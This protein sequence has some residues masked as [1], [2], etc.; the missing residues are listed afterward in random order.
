MLCMT[1]IQFEQ[2]VADFFQH[3]GYTVETTPRSYDYGVDIVVSNK[4]GRTA[5]QVKMYEQ[6]QVNYQDVMYLFAGKVIYGCSSG[7]LVTSGQLSANARR[8]AETLD[9]EVM[10]NWKS[11][12]LE[13][14][15]VSSEASDTSSQAEVS[16]RSF[17][18]VWEK[19]IVP[20][21][22]KK[23][24]TSTHKENLICDV[25]WDYIERESS[26][27]RASKISFTVFRSCYAYILENGRMTREEINHLY[28]KR[29]SAAIFAVL[30]C[31]PHLKVELNPATLVLESDRSQE[32]E[33]R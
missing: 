18:E 31:I 20:L 22:S 21:K 1:P 24:L 27:G 9:I 29:G 13:S 3:Q 5:I 19:Y 25:N 32:F 4:K 17:E 8:V 12:L 2:R 15:A 33:E 6:R 11:E 10:D 28:S 14:Q 16:A 30:A 7:I 26:N 23:I